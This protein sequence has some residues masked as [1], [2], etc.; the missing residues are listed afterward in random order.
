MEKQNSKELVDK[1]GDFF[2]CLV[3]REDVRERY[4]PFL[5]DGHLQDRP[6]IQKYYAECLTGSM[7]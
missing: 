6:R 2:L 7:A 3:L 5:P 4:Q 1:V